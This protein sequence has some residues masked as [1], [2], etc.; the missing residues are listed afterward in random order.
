MF[1]FLHLTIRDCRQADVPYSSLKKRFYSL[2]V[3]WGSR[4]RGGSASINCTKVAVIR[5]RA[6]DTSTPV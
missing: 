6:Q 2:F 3:P 5:R 1:C 4:S